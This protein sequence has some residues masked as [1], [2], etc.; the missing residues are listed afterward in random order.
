MFFVMRLAFAIIFVSEA[1]PFS[2]REF[3]EAL[4]LGAKFDARVSLVLLLPMV[5]LFWI[6]P[7]DPYKSRWAQKFWTLAYTAV[8]FGIIA[9]GMIDIAYYRYL[10]GRVNAT[11]LEFF[12]N[13]LISAEM[14][15]STYPVIWMCLGGALLGHLS[16][17]TLSRFIFFY[18]S[19]PP[20]KLHK[21]WFYGLLIFLFSV[22]GLHGK[23]SQYPL[24]WSEA[25]F[26]TNTF[27]SSLSMN[28]IHYFVDTFK[29]RKQAY[30][31]ANTKELYPIVSQYFDVS[32]P[33]VDSLHFQRPIKMGSPFTKIDPKNPPNIVVIILESL[34]A[35][36]TG[37]LG[38]PLKPTPYLDEAAK[39]GLLFTEYYVP[40]EATARSIYCLI[41]G[42]PDVNDHQGSSSRNPLIINQNT[43]ANAFTGYDKYYF[44]GGSANWGNIRGVITNNIKGVHLI[45]EENLT[46]PRTD[47]WG[48]SDLD[49]FKEAHQTLRDRTEQKPFLAF[50]QS[51]GFH[52]PYT[53]PEDHG[54]FESL[55]LDQKTLKKYGLLSND[56]LNSLRFQDYAFGEFYKRTKEDPKFKNTIFVVTGDHGLPDYQAEHVSPGSRHF[57]LE[58]WHVPLV[59]YG[60]GLIEPGVNDEIV[61]EP[62]I[63]PTLAGMTGHSFENTTFGRNIFADKRPT[64]YAFNFVY[65]QT[66]PQIG[67]LDK[68]FY[69]IGLPGNIR[70]LYRYRSNEPDKDVKDQY[71][72]KW[73]EMSRLAQGLYESAK[74]ML[75][76]NKK[77]SQSSASVVST[78][79]GP[80]KDDL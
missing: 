46:S 21:R 77:S 44:I 52:R 10:H 14:V 5:L 55:S 72:E 56:E 30:N 16:F 20:I 57:N 65:Y 23:L 64:R 39:G 13:P 15:W 74:Y 28:P 45:D 43:V 6:P 24:R 71:P 76:H 67:V 60:P 18:R 38:H 68:E 73:T 4:Y 36:K 27:I 66:P 80:E 29:N 8:F 22:A 40:S 69:A 33:S 78:K 35:Y 41:T 53:I 79:D 61:T 32:N 63:L 58:R 19:Q 47:V 9:T 34:A 12:K 62:D 51:A 25:Y 50:I 59:F 70:G 49:L 48:V 3:I 42:I 26:S 1:S 11:I 31:A 7:L 75:Y 54:D 37:V 2:S 17:V